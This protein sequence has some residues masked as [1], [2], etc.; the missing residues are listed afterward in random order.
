MRSNKAFSEN[1]EFLMRFH[2]LSQMQLAEATG[3]SQQSISNMVRG[4]AT[5]SAESVCKIAEFLGVSPEGLLF[6][7]DVPKNAQVSKYRRTN[8]SPKKEKYLRR[9]FGWILRVLG[10][11]AGYV[12]SKQIGDFQ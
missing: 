10:V 11:S 7:L 5:P 4:R 2:K 3:L 1:L 9:I 12:V 6:G 8:M